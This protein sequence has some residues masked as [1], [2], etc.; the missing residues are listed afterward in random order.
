MQRLVGDLRGEHRS[1][2]G[3]GLL[4]LV[5]C[6]RSVK[7]MIIK[8][9]RKEIT[10]LKASRLKKL[11]YLLNLPFCHLLRCRFSNN[12]E[13]IQLSIAVTTIILQGIFKKKLNEKFFDEVHVAH[14]FHWTVV[15]FQQIERVDWCICPILERVSIFRL[16]VQTRFLHSKTCMKSRLLIC[17]LPSFLSLTSFCL[18]IL[19]VEGYCCTWSHWMTHTHTFGRTPVDERSARRRDLCQNT[20]FTRD[21]YPWP[22]RYSNPQFQQARGRRLT[23]HTARPPESNSVLWNRQ[24][25]KCCFSDPNKWWSDGGWWDRRFQWH[26]CSNSSVRRALCWV[27]TLALRDRISCERPHASSQ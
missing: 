26:S 8:F 6:I 10:V 21:R 16:A 18:I 2:D 1:M 23:S 3:H 4:R 11:L 27:C 22:P 7:M 17:F 14:Q 20:T 12:G 9:C 25:P 15:I 13:T 5:L 24:C 19:G